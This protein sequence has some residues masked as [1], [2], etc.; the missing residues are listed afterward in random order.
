MS[1]EKLRSPLIE[2]G[3]EITEIRIEPDGFND[4]LNTV[5]SLR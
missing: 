3:F 5:V 2:T 1:P 4:H